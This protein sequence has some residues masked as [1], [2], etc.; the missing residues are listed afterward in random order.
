MKP[1]LKPVL[2]P[3]HFLFLVV[4]LILAGASASAATAPTDT[5]DV[6]YLQV[7]LGT[8]DTDEAWTITDSDGD[9]V[10]TDWSELIYGGVAVQLSRDTGRFQYG[11]ETS[12]LISFQNDASV[13][14]RSDADEG[15]DARIKVDNQFLLLDFAIG[16]F[17]SYRPWQHLRVYASAGPAVMF[18]TLS[19]GKNDV[20]IERGDQGDIDFSPD[21]R[22][23]DVDA[24]VYARVG[25][26]LI[27][28]KG[29]IVGASA[30]KVDG[31][32]DF[33]N[34]GVVELDDTQYF[35]SLGWSF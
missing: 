17:V 4:P 26:D 33:G 35:L 12:G 21:G 23:N 9:I 24:G 8:L 30:R 18:G 5:L 19:I 1:L 22:E 15:L 25:F 16:G 34:S 31:E 11:L 32:L 13:F 28:G 7:M 27:L 10:N 20:E 6:R 3:F 29:F 2:K 14:A